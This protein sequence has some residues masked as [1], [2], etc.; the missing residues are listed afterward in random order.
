MREGQGN[1]QVSSNKCW[2]QCPDDQSSNDVHSLTEIEANALSFKAL[3]Y[4]RVLSVDKFLFF[5]AL[6]A[7]VSP[8][9]QRKGENCTRPAEALTSN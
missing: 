9:A 6:W 8:R 5:I 7:L 3:L 1:E 2:E 4:L